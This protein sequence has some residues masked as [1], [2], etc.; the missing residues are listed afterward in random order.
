MEIEALERKKAEKA[1]KKAA[2]AAK[3]AAKAAAKGG[4]GAVE[5]G[6]AAD[7]ANG[8]VNGGSAA[9]A[10]NGHEQTAED[11]TTTG[12]LTSEK[13]ARDIKIIQFSLALYGKT[14]VQ[15]T[16]RRWWRC[17]DPTQLRTG[18]S[19]HTDGVRTTH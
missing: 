12:I 1:A 19:F 15:D 8:V 13:N 10:G 16:L 14:F 3:R 6:T 2:K 11:R 9:K 17:G 5:N 7:S 4:D 18:I